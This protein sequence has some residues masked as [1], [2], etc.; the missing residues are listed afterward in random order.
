MGFGDA[1]SKDGIPLDAI[2][3]RFSKYAIFAR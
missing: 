3:R 1:V 2:D